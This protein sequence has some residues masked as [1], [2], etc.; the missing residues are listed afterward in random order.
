MA[1][2]QKAMSRPVSSDFQTHL[3]LEP[4]AVVVDQ[5]DRGDRRVADLRGELRDVVVGLL[6][7]RVEDVVLPQG[8]KSLRLVLW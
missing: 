3:G 8:A 5:A 4:L 2:A 7:Q 6:R 1:W